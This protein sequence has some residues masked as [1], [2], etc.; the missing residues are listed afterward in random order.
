MPAMI[1]GAWAGDLSRSRL[2]TAVLSRLLDR[3]NQQHCQ[4]A[5]V[6]VCRFNFALMNFA[7][8]RQSK[9]CLLSSLNPLIH[10]MLGSEVKSIIGFQQ[11]SD[12]RICLVSHSSGFD[13]PATN[14]NS[15]MG[16]SGHSVDVS[17]TPQQKGTTATHVDLRYLIPV[18]QKHL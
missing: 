16:R 13:D 18:T 10:L 6:K 8:S 9:A 7:L 15:P 2:Q 12:H 14:T 11:V 3:A 5:I 4:I 1:L 17:G